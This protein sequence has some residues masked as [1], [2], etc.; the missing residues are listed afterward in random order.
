MGISVSGFKLHSRLYLIEF[1]NL[2][3]VSQSKSIR[4]FLIR[5]TIL[6]SML[7][8]LIFKDSDL[9]QAIYMY[10]EIRCYIFFCIICISLIKI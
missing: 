2:P 1:R 8:D 3:L 5:H 7:Q 6:A 4:Q 9:S 10:L